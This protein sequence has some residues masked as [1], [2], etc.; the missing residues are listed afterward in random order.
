MKD[1]VREGKGTAN[2]SLATQCGLAGRMQVGLTV[3]GR[4]WG[5]FGVRQRHKMV[6]GGCVCVCV[7]LSEG[8]VD[9]VEAAG[10]ALI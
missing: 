9:S 2:V 1:V 3:S 8:R 6:V 4:T 5:L 10:P 7:R